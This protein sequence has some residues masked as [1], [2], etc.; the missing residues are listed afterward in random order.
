M[1]K[2]LASIMLIASFVANAQNWTPPK[3]VTAIVGNAPGAG[4]E[5]A[6]RK[7]A[8]IVTRTTGINFVI[9]NRPG[10]DSVIAMNMMM[11]KPSD[12][13]VLALPSHM[14]TYVTNDIWEKNIKK[15]E[16]NS[17]EEVLSYG[18]APL[19]VVSAVRSPINTPADLLKT[20]QT[21]DRVINVAIGGGAHR[22]AFEYMMVK[23][24][25]DRN[26]IKHIKFNGPA[27]AVQSVASFDPKVAG[28]EIGIMPAAIALPL[29]QAGKVKFIG[30]TGTKKL[31]QI[32]TVPLLS[33][34]IPGVLAQAGWNIV[35]PPMT[36][37]PIVDWYVKEFG[38]AVKSQEYRQWAED[39][40]IIVDERDHTPEG[41]RAHMADLRQRFLPMAQ[42]IS[43][44]GN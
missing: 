28:T 14:S 23:T 36:P 2:I 5:I 42:Y 7:A 27:Q 25:A 40:L 19:A 22:M 9:E 29:V 39:N 15:F 12:G 43:Q 44:E 6:F 24:K 32:P 13:S 34:A 18:K 41:V 38:R 21:S 20:F 16:W 3:T 31:Q 11:T 37:R 26:Q 30:L 4:N 1:K 35:L 8:E 17:F 10:A 33:D